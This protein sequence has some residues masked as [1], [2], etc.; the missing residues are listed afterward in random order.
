M[1]MTH[2]DGLPT[3]REG[4]RAALLEARRDVLQA[5]H[6]AAAFSS[7]IEQQRGTIAKQEQTILELLYA[8]GELQVYSWPLAVRSCWRRSAM[9][10]RCWG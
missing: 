1:G 5:R 10:Q 4:L 3:T 6:E 2:K 7:T 8:P 9:C